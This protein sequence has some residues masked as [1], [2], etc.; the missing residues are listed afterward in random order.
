MINTISGQARN[1][2]SKIDP[3]SSS[4][5]TGSISI[6]LGASHIANYYSQDDGIP[7]AEIVKR[8]FENNGE[9]RIARLE[10]QRARARLTQAGSANPTLEV[11]QS[12]GRLVG[13]SG[14]RETSVGF[15]F[16]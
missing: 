16:P 6:P 10:V 4:E 9:I 14:D 7:L 12:T 13:S 3:I 11:E 1:A 2:P 8:A 15:S 5:V